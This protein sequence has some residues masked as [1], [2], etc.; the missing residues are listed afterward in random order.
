MDEKTAK[1]LIKQ[2]LDE[3]RYEHSIRVA[4]TAKKLAEIHKAPI[5]KVIIASLLHDYAKCQSKE[6]LKENISLYHLPHSLLHYHHELWHGPVAAKIMED[7]YAVRDDAILI[8]IYYHTTGLS[9]IGLIETIVFE[10]DYFEPAGKIPGVETIR[11][12]AKRDI[13]EAARVAS[14]NTIIYL[15]KKDAT[16]HPDSLAVYNMCTAKSY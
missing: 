1:Q 5:D 2:T 4:N 16:I 3:E 13:D 6:E 7:D 8:V 10:A 11:Q 9:V 12:L 14:K 15:M